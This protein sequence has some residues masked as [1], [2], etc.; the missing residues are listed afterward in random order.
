MGR[1]RGYLCGHKRVLTVPNT[2]TYGYPLLYNLGMTR[3]L[4]GIR[5]A[6]EFLEQPTLD[7]YAYT[8][9][10]PIMHP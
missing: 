7:T 2:F 5:E 6:A 1:N 10:A 8:T 3:K 9:K 4:V